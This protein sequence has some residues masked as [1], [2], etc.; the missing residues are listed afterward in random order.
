M[1]QEIREALPTVAV[2]TPRDAVGLHEAERAVRMTGVPDQI[3]VEVREGAAVLTL[4]RPKVLNAL[5][6][7][8]YLALDSALAGLEGR[9]DVRALILTGSGERA[10][11]A[12]ADLRYMRA[13]DGETRQQFILLTYRVTNRLASFPRPTI[14]GL[15]GY[16]LGGGFELAMACD[17]R[18]A[19]A[20]TQFGL[21]EITLGSVPGSGGLQRLPLLVGPTRARELIFTGRRLSADEALA[22]GLVNRVV[23]P[24]EVLKA[25]SEMA[26]T[27]AGHNPIAIE[28]AKLALQDHTVADRRLEARF[29]SLLS[30]VCQQTPHYRERTVR[31]EKPEQEA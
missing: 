4:N 19:G 24:E 26:Q 1:L 18:V 9:E 29:H 27:V 25:A 6:D 15:R 8:T 30:W 17:L 5:D 16:V 10:F 14:A 2:T 23:P 3:L 11:C 31:F 7:Q 28:H 21:P 22:W 20:D 12:G 13:L